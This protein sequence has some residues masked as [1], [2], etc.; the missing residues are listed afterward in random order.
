MKIFQ[1]NTMNSF[2]RLVFCLVGVHAVE[3]KTLMLT[4]IWLKASGSLKLVLK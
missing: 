4:F 2:N 3:D 1:A